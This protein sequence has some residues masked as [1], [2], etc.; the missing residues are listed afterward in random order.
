METTLF[1]NPIVSDLIS[2]KSFAEFEQI[3]EKDPTQLESLLFSLMPQLINS[4]VE[5]FNN[6]SER[7]PFIYSSM[8]ALSSLMTDVQTRYADKPIYPM[9]YFALVGPAGSNKGI[10]KYAS[11]MLRPIHQEIKQQSEETFKNIKLNTDT[12]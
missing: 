6:L 5:T 11:K 9:L 12:G 4:G 2:A 1:T 7:M 3:L 10:V 8:A